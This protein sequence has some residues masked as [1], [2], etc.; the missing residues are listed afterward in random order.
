VPLITYNKILFHTI[1]TTKF[2]LLKLVNP[3]PEIHDSGKNTVGVNQAGLGLSD[4]HLRATTELARWVISIKKE[5]LSSTRV[6]SSGI[7]VGL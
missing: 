1:I 2:C 5:I 6:M 7:D 4:I 3:E